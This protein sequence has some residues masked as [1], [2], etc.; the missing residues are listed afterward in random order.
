MR[1][2]SPAICQRPLDETA[3]GSG[4]SVA[5]ETRVP[6]L[7]EHEDVIRAAYVTL[8]AAD[9]LLQALAG[10]IFCVWCKK[11]PGVKIVRRDP[12]RHRSH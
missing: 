5:R 11:R 8:A 7:P 2:Q 6:A 12:A 4:A 10:Y 3:T 1:L 9:D